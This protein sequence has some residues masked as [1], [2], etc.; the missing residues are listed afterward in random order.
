MTA[1]HRFSVCGL[2]AV[3]VVAAVMMMVHADHAGQ[4]DKE[5]S[6]CAASHDQIVEAELSA[7]HRSHMMM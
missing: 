5:H 4:R 6:D 3:V 7:M 1:G 2:D